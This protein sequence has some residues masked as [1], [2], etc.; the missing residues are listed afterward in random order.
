M[1]TYSFRAECLEDVKRFHGECLKAGL[2]AELQAKPDD[3]F[4]D[5]DVELY[6]GA[7]LENLRNVMRQVIDGHVM[8]QT[9][10]ECPLAE[11]PLERDYDLH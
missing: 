3:Q 11:N 10:R 2:I 5:V 6:T 7:S 8:L 1:K 4:P 9:L